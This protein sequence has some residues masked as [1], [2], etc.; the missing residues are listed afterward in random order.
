MPT[1]RHGK[2]RRLLNEGK[3]KVVKKLPFTIQLLYDSTEFIQPV[4]LGI[5]S[6]SKHVGVSVVANNKELFSGEHVLRDGKTGV[7]NLLEARHSLRHSRRNRKTRYR[8]ARFNNRVRKPS[9]GYDKW[10]TPTTRTQIAGHEHII[11][12]LKKILPVSHIIIECA[13]IA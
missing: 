12:E 5:D 2:V 9:P 4:T 8:Q 7:T 13:C 1:E 11:R 6:G 3:A 10:F